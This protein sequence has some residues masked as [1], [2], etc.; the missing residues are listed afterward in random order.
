MP[1]SLGLAL[2]GG[3]ARGLAHAGVLMTLEEEGVTPRFVAGTS[4]GAIVG[5]MYAASQDMQRLS[6]LLGELDLHEMLGISETYRGM[7]ERTAGEA[8]IEQFT[9]ATWRRRPSPRRERLCA[10]IN[11]LCKGKRFRDLDIPL[12]CITADVDTGEEVVLRT[13][14]LAH[15]AA[16][17]AS[18]PGVLPPFPWRGR[19]LIDGGTVNNLPADVPL[20]MG[21]DTVLAVDV[22]APLVSDPQGTMDVLLQSYTITTRRLTQ[23]QL[24]LVR[25]TLGDRLIVIRPQVDKIGML[26]FHRVQEAIAAGREAGREAVR[27]LRELGV[28]AYSTIN[29]GE[30]R[31]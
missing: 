1:G 21:A 11:L 2:G 22:S 15:A 27:Q 12:G 31:S 28:A 18:L 19:F 17:S 7:V 4:M 13:G 25:T 26:E 14:P 30:K 8:V 24:D 5:A 23:V 3:G 16:A 6:Q 10:F 9:G 29:D 20:D